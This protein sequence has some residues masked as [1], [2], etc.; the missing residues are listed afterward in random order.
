M[1]DVYT[2]GYYKTF[3]AVTERSA[4]I[5]LPEL[6]DALN[7]STMVDIGCGAGGWL[8][9]AGRLGL[10]RVVG[11][12]G[13]WARPQIEKIKTAEFVSVDL[14]SPP[15][16]EIGVFDLVICAE[17]AEHLPESIADDL[18]QYLTSLS[19]NILF[20]AAIPHQEGDHHINLQWQSSWIKRF[21]DRG[22]RANFFPREKYWN[23]EGVSWYYRQNMILFLGK[24]AALSLDS[25]PLSVAD[26]VHPAMLDSYVKRYISQREEVWFPSFRFACLIV[27]RW[28]WKTLLGKFRK[29]QIKING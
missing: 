22:F 21:A 16:P 15:Y 28:F 5:M 27:A 13:P 25:D 6:V 26:I 14:S 10:K 18:V 8:T 4:Q 7:V 12:D 1:N 9:V 11:V 17:V 3:A 19:E 29:K 24:E 23:N 2:S 20:S